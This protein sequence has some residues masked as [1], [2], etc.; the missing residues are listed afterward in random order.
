[1]AKT[2]EQRREIFQEELDRVLGPHGFMFFVELDHGRW[3]ELFVADPSQS[4]NASSGALGENT[5]LKP[6][7]QCKRVILGNPAIALTMLQLD[8]NAGLAVPV[9]LLLVEEDEEGTRIV[10]ELPSA[11]IAGVNM[12]PEL[13]AAAEKLDEKLTALVLHIAS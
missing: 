5:I 10:Y 8:L 11:L 3:M 1:M 13:R 6:R 4:S 7:R 2:V 12:D 9:E